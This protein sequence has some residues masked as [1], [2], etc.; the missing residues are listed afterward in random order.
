MKTDAKIRKEDSVDGSTQREERNCVEVA[1]MFHDHDMSIMTMMGIMMVIF[2]TSNG[3]NFETYIVHSKAALLCFKP[4]EIHITHT[5]FLLNFYARTQ[6][7]H[8]ESSNSLLNGCVVANIF[9][10]SN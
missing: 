3:V 5:H 1:S 4:R 7:I 8:I 10:S 6:A 2:I 9:V